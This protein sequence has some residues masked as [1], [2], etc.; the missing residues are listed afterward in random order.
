MCPALSMI[1]ILLLLMIT[2]NNT[3]LAQKSQNAIS[4]PTAADIVKPF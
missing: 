4:T 2:G 3:L 1:I